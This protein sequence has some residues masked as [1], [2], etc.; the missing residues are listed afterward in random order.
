MFKIVFLGDFCVENASSLALG[1]GLKQIVENCIFKVCNFEAPIK[2]TGAKSIIKSGP[3]IEQPQNSAD[4]LTRN[5]FNVLLLANNHMMDYGD[6]GLE[7]TLRAFD[8]Q[9]TVGAGDRPYDVKICSYDDTKVGFLALSQ[10]EFGIVKSDEVK[11]NG[12]AWVCDNRIGD[13]IRTAKSKVDYLFVCPH[14]GIEDIFAPLPEW[15][16]QYRYFIECG[17]D[18]IIATHPHTPQGWEVYKGKYIFYSL[19]NFC[20]D[21]GNP[22]TE[23]FFNKG[24]CVEMLIDNNGIKCSPR[25]VCYDGRLIDVDNSQGIS[26][27]INYLNHLLSD[28]DDYDLY[29]DSECKKMYSFY[30]YGLLRSL[31]GY[32][33]GLGIRES[34]KL[35]LANIIK[36]EEY[37]FLLNAFQCESH[38]WFI[39]RYINIKLGKDS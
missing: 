19:G 31:K 16:E 33:C 25:A 22:A 37:P 5:G 14:A 4:F 15:R 35:F 38:R 9:V 28:K 6:E 30:K 24:L 39:E 13:I 18:A 32:S 8:K 29:L 21:L 23:P 3:A 20:F 12:V 17:A 34:I 7:T 27:H 26:S 36:K 11:R 1:E 2:V 10:F